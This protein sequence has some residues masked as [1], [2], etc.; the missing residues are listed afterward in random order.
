MEFLLW[1]K[2]LRT[3][4][5]LCEDVSLIPDLAQWVKDPVLLQAVV[6][7]TGA[8]QIHCCSRCGID[9]SFNSDSTPGPGASICC[10]YSHKKEKKN[11]NVVPELF[12][13]NVFQFKIYNIYQPQNVNYIPVIF[14]L[15][16]PVNN[17]DCFIKIQT[18]C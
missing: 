7:V 1:L 3:Q 11:S 10:G 14:K 15:Q 5:C 9:S 17:L 12:E 4:P 2:R 6:Q 16:F 13:K 18:S 8:A